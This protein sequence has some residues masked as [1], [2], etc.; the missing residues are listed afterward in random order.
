LHRLRSV[1]GTLQGQDECNTS[2]ERKIQDLDEKLMMVD[3]SIHPA[4][5]ELQQRFE[6]ELGALRRDNENRSA[7]ISK[8]RRIS[9]LVLSYTIADLSKALVLFLRR[10]A[11]Q[12]DE[13]LRL[14]QHIAA[15]SRENDF[16]KRKV[17]S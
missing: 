11:F 2:L 16:I 17:V 9:Y 10:N 7:K 12:S 6:R 3:S 4:I 5:L 8:D 13:N 14:Q 1:E 15:L